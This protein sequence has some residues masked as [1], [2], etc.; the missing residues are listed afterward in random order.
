MS[1]FRLPFPLPF[2]VPTYSRRGKATITIKLRDMTENSSTKRIRSNHEK[3]IDTTNLY[4]LNSDPNPL[5]VAVGFGTAY[6]LKLMHI[7]MYN[8]ISLLSRAPLLM[9]ISFALLNFKT[10][11]S[12]GFREFH[13]IE[14]H[15]I[16][17][18][19]TTLAT[20]TISWKDK[21]ADA[22]MEMNKEFTSHWIFICSRTIFPNSD[23]YLFI[24]NI[25]FMQPIAN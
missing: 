15:S 21:D 13:A 2:F 17:D 19:G 14:W 16:R 22:K 10:R 7:K 3:E 4:K 5:V 25:P 24:F 6:N 8:L 18:K 12:P 20:R 11:S 23:K 9:G 1:K